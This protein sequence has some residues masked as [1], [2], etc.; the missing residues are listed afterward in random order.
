MYVRCC[1]VQIDLF[2]QIQNGDGYTYTVLQ[3][4]TCTHAIFRLPSGI[5]SSA[6][7]LNFSI[8]MRQA[9]A[10]WLIAVLLLDTFLDQPFDTLRSHYLVVAVHCFFVLVL[11]PSS[12][13]SIRPHPPVLVFHVLTSSRLFV[14]SFYLLVSLVI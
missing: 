8:L 3:L 1:G 14:S 6:F 13:S 9:S 12:S 7:I 10:S 11:V 4:L 5:I 2:D